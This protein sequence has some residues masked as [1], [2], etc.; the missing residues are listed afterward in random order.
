MLLCASSAEVDPRHPL[1]LKAESSEVNGPGARHGKHTA[2]VVPA[3]SQPKLGVDVRH[4]LHDGFLG[5]HQATSDRGVA[6]ALGDHPRTS[7]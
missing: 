6:S 3:R 2:V 4:V 5:Y 7:V 1:W